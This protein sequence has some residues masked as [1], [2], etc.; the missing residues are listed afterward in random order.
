MAEPSYGARVAESRA[1]IRTRSP[2]QNASEETVEEDCKQVAK[3]LVKVQKFKQISGSTGKRLVS[4]NLD[5]PQ[6]HDQ[7]CTNSHMVL[8]VLTGVPS[9]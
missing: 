8:V 9:K 6:K 1:R 7:K 3:A 2:A 4:T 5:K